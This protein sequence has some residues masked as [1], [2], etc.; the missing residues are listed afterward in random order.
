MG[1]VYS[2]FTRPIRSF[3]IEN[4][5]HRVISKEKPVPAPQYPSVTKQKELV[6]KLYPNYMEIHYKKNKQL[7]EH[8]KNVY[9]TSNDSVRE[10]EG[11]AVSTK[12][13]PQDRK[14]PPELQF[15]FYQS[16]IIPE[17][18]CTLKQALTFIGKHNENS[19]EYTAEIIAIEYKL[20]KQ[21]V[22]NILKHFKI[23]HVRDVQQPDIV[24]DLAKI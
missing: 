15:G 2:Y 16:D 7:D 20:D 18:K 5:A 24:G 13:L 8:L 19:S 12:P 22:V 14:H 4:R 11:E 3:N 1:K 10:P 6:D 9:V 23:P 17:G 21:V